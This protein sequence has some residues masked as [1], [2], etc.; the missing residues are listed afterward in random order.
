MCSS[1]GHISEVV[2]PITSLDLGEEMTDKDFKNIEDIQRILK[3]LDK[4]KLDA[5]AWPNALE[6]KGSLNKL[7]DEHKEYVAHMEHHH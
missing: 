3:Y 4:G 2:R 6:L 5:T 1:K 7:L